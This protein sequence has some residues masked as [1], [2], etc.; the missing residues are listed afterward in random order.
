[1]QLQQKDI[2]SLR[3]ELDSMKK[4]RLIKE[5]E[6]TER[7]SFW[8]DRY[9]SLQEEC[10]GMSEQNEHMR[11]EVECLKGKCAEVE[12]LWQTAQAAFLDATTEVKVSFRR[13][14]FLKYGIIV[15]IMEIHIKFSGTFFIS[16]K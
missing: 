16:A 7:V 3:E 8:E 6:V 15:G 12:R 2:D 5:K 1:M 11:R 4:Q 9:K 14:S 13:C 10:K